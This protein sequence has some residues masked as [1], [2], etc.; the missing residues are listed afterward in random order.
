MSNTEIQSKVNELRELRRMAD[1]LTAETES[2]RT[3]LQELDAQLGQNA[4]AFS[5]IQM[6]V[7]VGQKILPAARLL[8][9]NTVAPSLQNDWTERAMTT[10]FPARTA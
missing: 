3:G 7:L 5:G 9:R 8:A 1:E 6:A 10:R 2:M 4:A